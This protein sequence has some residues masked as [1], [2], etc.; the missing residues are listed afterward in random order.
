MIQLGIATVL[1][2]AIIYFVNGFSRKKRLL[3][4][5][6]ELAEAELDRDSLD[7]DRSIAEERAHQQEIE[8]DINT[9]KVNNK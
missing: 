4:K 6:Q 2:L 1:I 5:E 9:I 8:K 7:I 3:L